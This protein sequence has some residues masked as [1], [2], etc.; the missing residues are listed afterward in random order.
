MTLGWGIAGVKWGA[1]SRAA[2]E[3]P[4]PCVECVVQA[5]GTFRGPKSSLTSDPRCGSILC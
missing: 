2:S 3:M 4:R 5:Q 1:R